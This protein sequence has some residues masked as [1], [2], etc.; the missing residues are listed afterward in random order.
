ME[1]RGAGTRPAQVIQRSR[2]AEVED[3]RDDDTTCRAA[4]MKRLAI[5][6]MVRLFNRTRPTGRFVSDRSTLRARSDAFR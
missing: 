4:A 5:G 3:V 6:P 2:L 1:S